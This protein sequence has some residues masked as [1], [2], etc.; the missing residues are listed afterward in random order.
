MGPRDDQGAALVGVGHSD[1]RTG[2]RARRDVPKVVSARHRGRLSGVAHG[3][4]R[5]DERGLV[6]VVSPKTSAATAS[7]DS[8][9]WRTPPA[10]DL[11]LGEVTS[12]EDAPDALGYGDAVSRCSVADGGRF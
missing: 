11:A 9:A 7:P 2:G 10:T 5:D 1:D 4:V 12:S 6:H 8:C 3:W